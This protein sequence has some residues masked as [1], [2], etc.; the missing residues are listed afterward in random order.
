LLDQD[1][2]HFRVGFMKEELAEFMYAH[3]DSNI[4]D[5][6]DALV[7]LVYV[8]LGTAAMMG[9]PWEAVWDEVHTANMKKVR[10]TDAS[11]SKRGSTLDVVKPVGWEKPELLQHLSKD[12]AYKNGTSG[13]TILFCKGGRTVF[14]VANTELVRR[15]VLEQAHWLQKMS[16]LD[17]E[18]LP[19]V[20]RIY[21]QGYEMEKLDELKLNSNDEATNLITTAYD[22]L[23]STVWCVP[24]V[25]ADNWRVEHRLYVQK[26]AELWA[27]HEAQ[28]LDKWFNEIKDLPLTAHEVHGDPTLDNYMTKTT[29][30]GFS[31]KIIDPIPAYKGMPS[32]RAVDIGKLLQSAVGYEAIKYG[33]WWPSVDKVSDYI[34]E[35]ESEF[36]FH[37]GQYFCAVHF[38]RLIP[39]QPEHMQYRYLE[40]LHELC[41]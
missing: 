37:A 20:I 11:Q 19:I 22:V 41:L 35:R 38:L 4:V 8:V 27:P 26:R 25:T 31:L 9:V 2:F 23:R 40:V 7:D 17:G 16:Q 13:A 24:A 15:R 30:S 28:R 6:V 5:A 36:D 21:P 3:N 34:A 12:M 18:P 14:K 1:A 10:A 39:Y 29:A 32:L 33:S